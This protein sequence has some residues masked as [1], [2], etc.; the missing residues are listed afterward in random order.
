MSHGYRVLIRE[1]ITFT[2][3]DG[4]GII[5]TMTCGQPEFKF[6]PIDFPWSGGYFVPK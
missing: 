5:F 2:W 4:T 1:Y 3:K 6:A